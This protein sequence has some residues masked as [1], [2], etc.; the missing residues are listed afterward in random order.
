MCCNVGLLTVYSLLFIDFFVF[1]AVSA[2]IFVR[3]K[4]S[5]AEYDS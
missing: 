5:F 3:L 1:F 2:L 4:D